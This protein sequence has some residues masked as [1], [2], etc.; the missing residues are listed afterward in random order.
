MLF[1]LHRCVS[2]LVVVTGVVRC[3]YAL[4]FI[5]AKK[6][7][8]MRVSEKR[9]MPAKCQKRFVRASVF[10]VTRRT[11]YVRTYQVYRNTR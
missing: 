2:V 8:Q 5:C 11:R 3:M 9:K 4:Y 10:C 7:K 1:T 6:S